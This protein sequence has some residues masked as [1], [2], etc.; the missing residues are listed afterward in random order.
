MNINELKIYDIFT[1]VLQLRTIT[2]MKY[3]FLQPGMSPDEFAV[4]WKNI[5]NVGVFFIFFEDYIPG[6]VHFVKNDPEFEEFIHIAEEGKH[7][8][9]IIEFNKNSYLWKSDGSIVFHKGKIESDYSQYETKDKLNVLLQ[10]E[11]GYRHWIW[12]PEMEPQQLEEWWE[13]MD[14]VTKYWWNPTLLPGK[15]LLIKTEDQVEQME[16]MEEERIHYSGH[17]HM[18]DDSYL[19]SPDGRTIRHKGC[20]R[21]EIDQDTPISF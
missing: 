15:V 7:W 1:L 3:G 16:Q 5:E 11:Y 21:K 20:R 13:N 12:Q 2:G 18:D 6:K 9:L 14:Q 17:I 8:R 4:W 19:K 10:E